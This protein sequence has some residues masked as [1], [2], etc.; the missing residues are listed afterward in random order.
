MQ[1]LNA[2]QHEKGGSVVFWMRMKDLRLKDNKALSLASQAAKKLNKHL[3]ILH[4]IS[5]GDYEAHDR[6]PV[7]ID[8]VLRNLTLLQ[9]SL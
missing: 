5:P 6:A 3:I 4:V 9:A 2:K 1:L 8:F 7:R